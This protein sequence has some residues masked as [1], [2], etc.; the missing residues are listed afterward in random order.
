MIDVTR[1]GVYDPGISEVDNP[2]AGRAATSE[3]EL[4]PEL[5]QTH[6]TQKPLM[7]VEVGAHA[8]G[9]ATWKR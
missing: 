9:S 1:R 6:M 8:V 4:E 2:L 5:I 3:L 7:W